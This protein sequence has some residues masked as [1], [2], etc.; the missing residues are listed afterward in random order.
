[1]LVGYKYD[2]EQGSRQFRMVE[3]PVRE[4]VK[5]FNLDDTTIFEDIKAVREASKSILYGEETSSLAA[6]NVATLGS[7][8]LVTYACNAA[9][10]DPLHRIAAVDF[11]TLAMSVDNTCSYDDYGMDIGRDEK[12]MKLDIGFNDKIFE[13]DYDDLNDTIY[14]DKTLIL[15]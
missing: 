8:S 12:E 4:C 6:S 3:R 9:F 2:S 11:G 1:M 10:P 13:I 5:L 14:D 15:L 7:H